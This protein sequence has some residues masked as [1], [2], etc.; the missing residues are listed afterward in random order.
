MAIR[1]IITRQLRRLPRKN[2]LDADGFA[3]ADAWMAATM[4]N[5]YPLALERI[6]RGLTRVTLNPAT[7]LISLD[8]RYVN[9]GWLVKKGSQ[10][11]NCGST[12]GGL[13]DLSS[14]G[15][16]LSN[17]KSTEDTSSGRV[18]GQFDDFPGLRNYRAEQNGAEWVSQ[19]GTSPGANRA[20]AVGP[21]LPVAAGCGCFPA[22]L[23]A[24]ISP[25][26]RQSSRRGD[27]KKNPALRQRASP[28]R[29]SN[30]GGARI[31]GNLQSPNFPARR[32]RLRKNLRMPARADS[33]A[34][35]GVSDFGMDLTITGEVISSSSFTF[36]RTAAAVR[37]R[38]SQLDGWIAMPSHPAIHKSTHPIFSGPVAAKTFP[39][40]AQIICAT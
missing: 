22:G 5:R 21:G 16:L 10:L 26:G 36:T 32:M 18:A 25:R 1:S 13:D 6:A 33:G 3:T 15:I 17:F 38:S 4:T 7:I 27:D 2:R 31:A 28:S 12:H 8:N 29:G 37:R 19:A 35:N 40:W 23:V 24:A 30:A 20:H 11:V 34:A 14:D 39:V 9:A